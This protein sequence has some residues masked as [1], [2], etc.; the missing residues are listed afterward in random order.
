MGQLR[1]GIDVGGTKIEG[2]A[3][4][5]SREVARL[6]VRTPRDNYPATVDAVADMVHALEE[7][8]SGHGS[9]GI[10][11][12]G[13]V[14]PMT[15]LVKNANSIWLIGRPLLDDLQHRLSRDV[16]IAND[17]NCFAVSEASDGAAEG[18][19]VVFGAIIGTG[20]GAGIV[21]RGRPLT[22]PNGTAGEW[23][24]NPLPWP[25]KDE[26]PGPPCYCGRTGCI[27]TF[28][29]GPGFAADYERQTGRRESPQQIVRRALDGDTEAAPTL[30]RYER[31]MAK[32][33]AAVINMVD[34]DVIVLGG[35][36]SNI[37]HLYDRVPQLWGEWVFAAGTGEVV[38]T[39]LV[40]ARHGDSSGVRGAV[41]L[42]SDATS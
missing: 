26:L 7:R 20:T 18:A 19:E 25:D 31:R 9:V 40:R 15:G 2:I 36:M 29:S 23:G 5:G 38:R 1:I 39:S 10:G 35:G 6:R 27:E 37:D 12:P 41:W 34:P 11:I 32:A 30:I 24:H 8:A 4:D 33:L 17:A 22:G 21:V 42:W 16:R 13:T 3:L 28:L 14:L